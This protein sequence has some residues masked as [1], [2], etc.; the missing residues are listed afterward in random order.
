VRFAVESDVHVVGVSS[1]A[2]GHMMLVPELIDELR[3]QGH[4]EIAV[5]VGGVIPPQDYESL[6]RA[7][8]SGI[9]GPGTAIPVAAQQ[10]LRVIS[11]TQVKEHC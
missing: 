3:K 4:Q 9:F 8:V 2:G 11:C 5:V 7:G 10:L 6:Y 1:L